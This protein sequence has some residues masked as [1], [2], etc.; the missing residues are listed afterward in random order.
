ML[1]R[2]LLAVRCDRV[3]VLHHLE[4]LVA[5]VAAKPHALADDLQHIHDAELIVALMGAQ[6]AVIEMIDRQQ[7][8]NAGGLCGVKF[9]AVEFALVGGQ[10]GR[11]A[12]G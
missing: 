1:A 5:I 10:R 4:P 12:D 6:V 7:R 2:K 11:Q 3:D 9:V 8:I